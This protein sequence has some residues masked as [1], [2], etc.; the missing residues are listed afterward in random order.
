MQRFH[1]HA[2]Q[3]ISKPIEEVFCFYSNVHHLEA[4]T[5]PWLQFRVLTPAPVEIKKG[6]VIDCRLRLYGIPLR[7]QSEITNW[8]PPHR[9]VDVQLRGPYRLWVHI[10]TFES[11][12]E[13]TRVCDDVEYAVW[14]GR[15]AQRWLV[16]PDLKR[17][18]KFRHEQL[19]RILG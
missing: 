16:E 12:A 5:P 11:K 14:G 13:T 15:W 6:V 19:A 18:F 9:F 2:E 10:H 7:W 3:Q 1:F 8:S 17:I 4:L